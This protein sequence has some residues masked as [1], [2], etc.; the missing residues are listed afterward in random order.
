[1]AAKPE[2]AVTPQQAEQLGLFAPGG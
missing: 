2:L 1:L